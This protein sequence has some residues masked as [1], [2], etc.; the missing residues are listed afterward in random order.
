MPPKL[1]IKKKGI[2]CAKTA[3]DHLAVLINLKNIDVLFMK[4]KKITC[5][6]VVEKRLQDMTTSK[7]TLKVFTKFLKN[8]NNQYKR[9]YIHTT[10]SFYTM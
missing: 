6:I 10:F 2:M 5:A 7:N 4:A 8:L 3:A 9:Y 1:F